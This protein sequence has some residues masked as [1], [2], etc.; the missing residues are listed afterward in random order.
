MGVAPEVWSFEIL[1]YQKF[2]DKN[3]N[4]CDKIFH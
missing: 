3:M 2:R 1:K 4:N